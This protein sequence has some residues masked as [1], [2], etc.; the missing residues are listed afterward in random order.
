VVPSLDLVYRSTPPAHPDCG[1]ATT[2]LYPALPFVEF[3][4]H[5]DWSW[6]TFGDLNHVWAD[7]LDAVAPEG[8][9]K[10][11]ARVSFLNVTEMGGQRP[12][13]HMANG[14]CLHVSFS[15]LS[16]ALTLPIGLFHSQ[17]SFAE[18]DLRSFSFAVGSS[19]HSRHLDQAFMDYNY[20]QLMM[21]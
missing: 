15:E 8:V 9:S 6:G 18:A 4:K 20:G 7:E 19:S 12:D 13:A 11:G 1:K 3:Y 5:P 16:S 2:P 14:D 17:P 21:E 10:T